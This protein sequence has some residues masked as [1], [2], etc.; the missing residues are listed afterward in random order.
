ME[1]SDGMKTLLTTLNAKYIH[2]ALALHTLRAYAAKHGFTVAIREFTIN[3]ALDWILGQIVREEPDLVGFSCNIW[4]IEATRIL[5]RRLKTVCPHIHVVLGGPEVTPDP[6]GILLATWADFAVLGEGEEP[7]RLLLMAL[8]RGDEPCGLPGL[9]VRR[10]AVVSWIPPGPP[11]DLAELP[12]PYEP[13]ALQ[14]PGRI[15]YYETSRGCPFSCAYCLSGQEG[16]VRYLPLD[17]VFAELDL[18]V[19]AGIRQV[20]LVDR[21][22]NVEPRRTTAILRYI[23]E[24]HG[25]G[26]TNFH[27]ELVAEILSE[28]TIEILNQA[29]PG[30]FRA[31]IGI[32]SLNPPTLRAIHRRVDPVVLADRVQRLLAPGN[33][34]VHL[35]LIAGLPEEGMAEF[36]QTFDW[37]YRLHPDELQLGILKLLK[38]SELGRKGRVLGYLAT[39][40]APYEVLITPWLSFNELRQLKTMAVL[41]EDYQNSG[42]F[43]HALPYLL[44]ARGRSPFWTLMKFTTFWEERGYDAVAHGL[45]ELFRILLEAAEESLLTDPGD[46]LIFKELLRLDR[47]LADWGYDP[48][49]DGWGKPPESAEALREQLADT[50]W[51]NTHLP[52][53]AA[54]APNDRRRRVRLLRLRVDPESPDK[55]PAGEE[56][57]LLLYRPVAG[58]IKYIKFDTSLLT[59]GS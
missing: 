26:Q 35:D 10:G 52:D 12:F 37:T 23:L 54:L 17:R 31:E 51:V 8:H 48:A 30:L 55:A 49:V 39:E 59:K 2:T 42:H 15:I 36:A 56:R 32:Q 47:A 9:A 43:R 28:E 5:V 38:G 6:E 40:E 18:L 16:G 44:E 13:A 53:L 11:L 14:E 1:R 21:T 27:L 4:N 33:V 22:F 24:R 50:A 29:P 3:Q 19:A 34:P 45:R 25:T 41:V 58:R 20:K 57:V 7:L 46:K